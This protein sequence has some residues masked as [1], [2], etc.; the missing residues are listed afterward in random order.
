[1]V[2]ATLTPTLRMSPNPSFDSWQR[3]R[4]KMAIKSYLSLCDLGG[5]EGEGGGDEEEN[6][7][8]VVWR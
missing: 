4:I 3:M 1:M 6:L 7:G 5:R 8:M 2:S